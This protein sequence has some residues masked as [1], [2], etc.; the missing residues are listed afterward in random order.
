MS[1]LHKSNKKRI[2]FGVCGGLSESTGI[3]P[4]I[5]RIGFIAGAIFTGSILFW[6]YLILALVLPVQDD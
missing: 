4:S 2:L 3:D 5:L 6:T 1:Q